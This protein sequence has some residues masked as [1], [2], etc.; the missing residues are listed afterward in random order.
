MSL[1]PS[2]PL[3]AGLGL[4]PEH[5]RA[6]LETGNDGLWF[7]V[8]PENYMVEGGPRLAW[9]EAIRDRHPLSF[10][11]VGASLGGLDEFNKNHLTALRRLI[12]RYQP[13]QVSEHAT[14]SANDGRYFADLLPLPRTQE[15]QRHL[16]IRIDAFQEA[17]GRRILIENPTNYLHFSSEI[18][19]PGFL[20]EVARV[21]GC[22]LL[23][24][25]NNVWVSAANTGIDPYAYIRE[26]PSDLVGE[27]HIAGHSPDPVLGDRFLI[28]SH[29][30][31]VSGGVWHLLKH[32]LAHWG[33][34]PVLIERDANIPT[35]EELLSE[36][37]R[38]ESF[39]DATRRHDH[40][41]A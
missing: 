24:D 27:I 26:I 36:R 21:S 19:E 6:A 40:D 32:A 25:L 37:N 7:E 3:H 28:D 38:A 1:L 39:I 16:T 30:E 5:Y 12:E 34:R 4:K 11:G 33:P 22:G 31:P 41:A 23:M 13:A 9:L 29:G 15:A 18:D 10:H 2:L 8:H 20:V 17:I 14:F 35:F